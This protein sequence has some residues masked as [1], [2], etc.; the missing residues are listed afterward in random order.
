[1]AQKPSLA[2][3]TRDFDAIE[4][5]KRQ[6]IIHIIQKTYEQFGYTPLE[7]P[8]MENLSTL[9]GKYGEEGERLLF[10]LLNQGEKLAKADI[11]A[12][13][14]G[15]LPR[16]AT[17]LAERGLRYDLT[18]PFARYVVMNQHKLVFPYKR[19]QIQPVWRGDRPQRGRYREFYQC[20]ADVVGSTSLLNE[21]ELVQIYDM[22]FAQLQIPVVIKINNRKILAAIAEVSN[23]SHQLIDMTIALD[24]LDKVGMEG[25]RQ[26]M[27]Q[28][29]IMPE[30]QERI[31]RCLS[32]TGNAAQI[33]AHLNAQLCNSEIGRLGI[34]ELQ[35]LLGYIEQWAKHSPLKNE[36]QLDV[37]L[38]R[39]LNYYTGTILEVVAKDISM[40]SLGGG[41]RYDNLTD[42]FGLSNMSG[43]GISFG[44]DRLY[45]VMEEQ[46]LFA[47]IHH[48]ATRVLFINFGEAAEI[49]AFAQLQQLRQHQIA[50]EIYP[51]GQTKMKKQLDYANKKQIPFVI[52]CGE[53]EIEQGLI[54]LKNM[55][56]GAQQ[57]LSIADAI[58]QLNA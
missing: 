34:A 4:V 32:G 49:Y 24:K 31:V 10:R 41:G 19:Y 50:A 36:L 38:A 26:E 20:D 58:A 45:D 48:S 2:L 53:S 40:G 28:R 22:V 35:T 46:G 43:V 44:L 21:A 23:I 42:T 39:G 3:G 51:D 56:T 9:T 54:G 5:K 29:G 57:T 47:H 12:F 15:N 17:S 33:V 13:T 8:A 30:A 52:F 1:M 16:F 18:I 25:V 14:A 27:T 11:A 55:I 6:Y 7:T 37:T